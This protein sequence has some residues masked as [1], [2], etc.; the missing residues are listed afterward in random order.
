MEELFLFMDGLLLSLESLGI[1]V[2]DI[3]F[4]GPLGTLGYGVVRTCMSVTMSS[5]LT[6]VGIQHSLAWTGV[7]L[8]WCTLH[9][10][11]CS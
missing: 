9:F 3:L 6:W 8:G 7:G 4:V 11:C 1:D 10:F 5:H 2:M